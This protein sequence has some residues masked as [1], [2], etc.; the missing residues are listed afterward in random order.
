VYTVGLPPLRCGKTGRFNRDAE[1]VEE[2]G[3]WGGISPGISP[4]LI[5]LGGLGERRKTIQ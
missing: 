2:V 4:L 1:G 5:R 3:K